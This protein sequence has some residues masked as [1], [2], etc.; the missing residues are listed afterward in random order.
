MIQE[1]PFEL[2][3]VLNLAGTAQIM[4]SDTCLHYGNVLQNATVADTIGVTNTGCDTLNIT[5]ATM[6][7]PDFAIVGGA[8]SILPGVT[9]MVIIEFTPSS[10]G[11]I[12]GNLKCNHQCGRYFHL[13]IRY[14]IRCTSCI[15]YTKTLW[16]SI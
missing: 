1:G 10:V 3:V 13:F 12:S 6:T 8:T 15:R 9:G 7:N 4:L 2:P 14:W 11:S 16:W 5:S